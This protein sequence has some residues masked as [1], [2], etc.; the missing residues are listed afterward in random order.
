MLWFRLLLMTIQPS[1]PYTSTSVVPPKST[2]SHCHHVPT[3]KPF[4]VCQHHNPCSPWWPLVCHPCCCGSHLSC[5]CWSHQSN[6]VSSLLSP[7]ACCQKPSI[8]FFFPTMVLLLVLPL[9]QSC[10]LLPVLSSI[11]LVANYARHVF[12]LPP[13]PLLCFFACLVLSSHSQQ[14]NYAH[15]DWTKIEHAVACNF[16]DF[17]L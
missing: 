15:P 14:V 1:S 7:S 4:D 12:G 2:S 5:A 3:S 11:S 13:S 8:S 17:L 9:I 10:P 6:L 16:T